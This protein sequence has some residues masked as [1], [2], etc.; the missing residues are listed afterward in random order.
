[1]LIKNLFTMTSAKEG[2]ASDLLDVFVPAP[3]AFPADERTKFNVMVHH[4]NVCR[5]LRQ[6]LARALKEHRSLDAWS[7]RRELQDWV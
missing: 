1:M 2:E 4:Q 7:I 5:E 3:E 6:E